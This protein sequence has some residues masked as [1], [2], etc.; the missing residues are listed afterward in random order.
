MNEELNIRNEQLPSAIFSNNDGGK[1]IVEE[2][3]D[4]EE[5]NHE[6]N[7]SISDIIGKMKDLERSYSR[8]KSF[9]IS[10]NKDAQ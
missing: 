10:P 2:M 7:E 8:K 9:S 1:L 4:Q 3:I 5:E 6:N